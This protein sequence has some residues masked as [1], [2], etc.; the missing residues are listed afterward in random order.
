MWLMAYGADPEA[1]LGES[2]HTSL[3]WAATCNA[4]ECAQALIKMGAKLDLFSVAGIGLL[5]A[6]RS[7]FSD[8]GDLRPETCRTGSS[9]FASDG[10][11]LSCPPATEVERISDALVMAARNGQAEVVRFLLTTGPDVSFRGFMGGTALHWAHFGG[12]PVVVEMLEA[13]GANAAAR[14]DILH[15]TPRAFGVAVAANW[16]FDFMVRK[17]LAGDPVLVNAIDRHTSPLHEAARGGHLETVRILLEHQA[18]AG[19][20]DSN[21]KTALDLAVENGHAAVAEMLQIH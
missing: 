18:D 7:C 4:P 6:V 20:R 19:F 5:D 1:K 17:L 8:S 9:R 21:G 13:A 2:G 14:D 16:G 10:K 15:C 11:R 12:S 3:S